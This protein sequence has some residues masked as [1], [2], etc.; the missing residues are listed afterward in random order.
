M[1]G[2][3]RLYHMFDKRVGDNSRNTDSGHI[4]YTDLW[5]HIY[6][7]EGAFTRVVW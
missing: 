1:A 2:I 3:L 6:I 5:A 4:L 7:W